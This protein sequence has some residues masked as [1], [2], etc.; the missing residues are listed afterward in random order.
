LL[1]AAGCAGSSFEAPEQINEGPLRERA[2][3]KSKENIRVS[4]AVPTPEEIDAI[5]G[6]D[7]Y[8]NGI[9]PLWLEI[10][11]QGERRFVFLPAGIDPEYFAPLEAAYLY[12]DQF[13][14]ESYEAFADHF[15]A[16][17]LDHRSLIMPG[18]TISGF[19][20]ANK[21]DP[22][23]I[24][25]IDLVGENWSERFDLLVPLPGT[26]HTVQ[27]IATLRGIYDESEIVNIEDE[28]E[29]RRALEALP[30]CTSNMMGTRE[31]LPLNLVVIGEISNSAPAFGRRRYRYRVV[32]PAYV[33][34]RQQDFSAKKTSR[35][36]APQPHVI[37]AWL[38]P[39][40][41]RGEPV[42][43]AQISMPSGGRFAAVTESKQPIEPDLDLARNDVVQEMMYSQSLAKIGFVKTFAQG[44]APDDAT[45]WTDGL[46]AVLL[47]TGE[48]VS[49]AEID[50]FDWERL[51]DYHRKAKS[52]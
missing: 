48:P 45:Y 28:E 2:V 25:E 31:D 35:W 49:L 19:V 39:L 26:D 9:Q 1:L 16:V 51:A 32:E 37:R 38:T 47:F 4:A 30:C 29:L 42:T 18:E 44:A 15:D 5:F 24:V 10:S 22:T 3:T 13:T 14:E 21:V 50:F 27:A 20:Y 17:S 23:M 6:V 7:L 46:R 11:N 12:E 36:I 34:G 41:F 43:I 8:D 40:R 52:Q 33:F